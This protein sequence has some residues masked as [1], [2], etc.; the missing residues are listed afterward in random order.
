MTCQRKPDLVYNSPGIKETYFEQ[1]RI[2]MPQSLLARVEI[3][4]ANEEDLRKGT[5]AVQNSLRECK[6]ASGFGIYE[7]K[8]NFELWFTDKADYTI[9][10]QIKYELAINH[11]AAFTIT[12]REFAETKQ[13]TI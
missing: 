3:S 1:S 7:G 4:F 5:D 11:V 9:L 12:A 13:I 10:N 6:T 8:I 2:N